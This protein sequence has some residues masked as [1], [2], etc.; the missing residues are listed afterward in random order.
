M[1]ALI[2]E[3]EPLARTAL[4]NILVTR[5]DIED[6]ECASD[7]VEALDKLD[8]AHYDLLLLDINMPEVSGFEFLERLK[9]SKRPVPSVIFVTAHDEYAVMAFEQ[10]AVD[11]V[12]KT[13]TNQR[14]HQALDIALR[15][16]S[17][18]RATKLVE[19]FPHLQHPSRRDRPRIAIKASGR[20]LFVDPSDVIVAEAQGNYVLL[21]REGGCYLLRESISTVAKK[22]KPYGFIRI[23]RST[24]VNRS[25]VEEICPR[26]TGEYCLRVKGGK[27][28]TVTRTYKSH[29]KSLAEFWIGT[30]AFLED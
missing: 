11:Y 1:R 12:L 30:E 19:T 21:Q 3:D 10:H 28:Y 29:L 24:L 6:V 15:R 26:S 2:I 4:A 14:V 17:A 16:T 18:E 5:S 25:F 9:E 27:E 13:F 23:H 8:G 20:I 7:A 22:L